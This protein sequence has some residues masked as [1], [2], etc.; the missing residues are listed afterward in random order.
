MLRHLNPG[1]FCVAAT[2]LL[3]VVAVWA[4]TAVTTKPANLGYDWIPFSLL[5]MP[6]DWVNARLV[7]PGLIANTVLTYLLGTL[8]HAFWRRITEP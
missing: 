7:L 1:G 6:W 5:A 4:L 2:Y 8:L 3:I